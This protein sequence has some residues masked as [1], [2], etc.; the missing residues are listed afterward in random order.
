[1]WLRSR[2]RRGD[3]MIDSIQRF[4]PSR[5]AY[6]ATKDVYHCPEGHVL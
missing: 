2:N 4:G 3:A 1:M 6:D 5:F